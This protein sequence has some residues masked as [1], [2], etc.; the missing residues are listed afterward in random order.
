MVE[1]YT[2]YSFVTMA[3]ND[4]WGP[5]RLPESLRL[6]WQPIEIKNG[7]ISNNLNGRIRKGFMCNVEW[8][9]LFEGLGFRED[10]EVGFP[11]INPSYAL[12]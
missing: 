7:E 11:K 6:F 1:G 10:L 8:C 5:L 9:K 12:L 2:Q 3:F 4:D